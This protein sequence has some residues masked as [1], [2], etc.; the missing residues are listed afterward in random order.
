M[1]NRSFFFRAE[2][3]ESL[4]K[5]VGNKNRIITK[6]AVAAFLPGNLPFNPPLKN[7]ASTFR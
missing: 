5:T 2:M 4:I 3:T 7:A 6:T 1:R